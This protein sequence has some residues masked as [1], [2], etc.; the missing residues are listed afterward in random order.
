[1]TA[2]PEAAIVKTRTTSPP[3]TAA[4]GGVVQCFRISV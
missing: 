1:M 2:A 3:R 4:G